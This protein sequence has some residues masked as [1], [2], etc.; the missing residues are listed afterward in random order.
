[1]NPVVATTAP[2]VI[3]SITGLFEALVKA[4]VVSATSTPTGAGATAHVQDDIQSQTVDV[5][6][7]NESKAEESRAYK[8]AILAEEVKF[9]SA[10]ISRYSIHPVNILG[11]TFLSDITRRLCISSMTVCPYNVSSV[12]SD[13]PTR[14]RA[15]EP[16][17]STLT[18]I[19]GR[20]VRH[21]RVLV[22]VIVVAGSL[23][24]R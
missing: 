1:V 11:L 20:T 4:G 14:H 6:G 3:P 22:A 15:R 21:R 9:S 13:F 10:D 19:S 17:K 5:Q 2:P 8:K 12:V 7:P 18:C 16:C 23:V 24:L